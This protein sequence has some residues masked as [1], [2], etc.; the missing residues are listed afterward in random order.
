MTRRMRLAAILLVIARIRNA[1]FV[2]VPNAGHSTYWDD[3][4]A[5]NRVVL[6]FTRK[7]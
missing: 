1:E 5:F 2:V 7:H 6:A 3:P 4:E